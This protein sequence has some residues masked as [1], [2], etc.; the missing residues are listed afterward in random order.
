MILQGGEAERG[1]LEIFASSRDSA[2]PEKNRKRAVDSLLRAG[3][4]LAEGLAG[5]ITWN[6]VR[7]IDHDLR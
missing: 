7:L 6:R 4:Q 3:L 2:Q 1:Y 5:F